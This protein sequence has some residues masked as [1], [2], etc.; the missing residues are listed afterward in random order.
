MNQIIPAENLEAQI[1]NSNDIGQLTD[2]KDKAEALRVFVRKAEKGFAKQNKYAEVKIRAERRCG[3]IL[4]TEIQHGGD[5][6]SKSRFNGKT[7]KD[8]GI[9]K[10]QSHHWQTVAQFPEDLFEGHIAQ[11]KGSNKELTS[12]GVYRAASAYRR[13]RKQDLKP[14]VGSES[15]KTPIRTK[16]IAG[17]FRDHIDKFENIDA[18]ITDPPY[19][20]KH[21]GLY[22][23]L[24]RFA[25]KV[26][27]PGG[28]LF[29]MAIV[30][31][32]PEILD[33]MRPHIGYHHIISY[34]MPSKLRCE[35]DKKVYIR[36]KAI[37]WFVNGKYEG[38]CVKNVIKAAPIEKSLHP[39]QQTSADFEELIEKTTSQGGTIIDPFFGTGSLGVAAI[40][41]NRKIIGIEIDPKNL[42]IAEKR[43]EWFIKKIVL[44]S[45]FPN[46]EPAEVLK[47]WKKIKG[48]NGDSSAIEANST[49]QSDEQNVVQD[50][51][52]ED[53]GTVFTPTDRPGVYDVSL[54]D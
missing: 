30:R 18:I 8:L 7:L 3:E 31:Y 47:N 25:G 28:S 50:E 10:N 23:D 46:E 21:L 41:L 38:D 33:L 11:L 52:F 53:N 51:P 42:E 14:V 29:T 39:W 24:A 34:Y 54:K 40:M 32:L 19:A 17:D 26:L 27:K 16:M 37:L 20:K 45:H 9:S 36:W 2:I 5:R 43:L 6:K 13:A 22:E 1:R 35:L 49:S 44:P 12:I 4:A 15:V 48:D